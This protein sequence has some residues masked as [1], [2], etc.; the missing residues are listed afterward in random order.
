MPKTYQGASTQTYQKQKAGDWDK[1]FGVKETNAAYITD[2]A[3]IP[4]GLP[5]EITEKL[6]ETLR[7]PEFRQV[8][9]ISPEA[10]EEA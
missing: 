9:R 3:D 7:N 2:D 6:E 4:F 8:P 10:K 1:S 5:E